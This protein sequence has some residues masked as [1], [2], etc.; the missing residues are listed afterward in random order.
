[1]NEAALFKYVGKL[2][3]FLL[4][5]GQNIQGV[6]KEKNGVLYVDCD[7]EGVVTRW[8]LNLDNIDAVGSN[9]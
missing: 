8:L 6:L 7:K 4:S 3:T 1:M 2:C 9:R 5:G